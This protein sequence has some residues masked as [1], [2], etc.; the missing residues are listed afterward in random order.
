[1]KSLILIP[2]LLATGCTYNHT[3]GGGFEARTATELFAPSVTVI[4]RPASD[5]L[6]EYVQVIGGQ[7]VFGQLSGPASAAVGGW[8]IGEGLKQSGTRVNQSGGGAVQN[9]E[10]RTS[11]DQ[12]QDQGQNV[13]IK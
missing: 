6:P 10:Q 8:L 9:Q 12:N 13:N 11:Q 3:L 5:G 4:H 7:S 1:M 2:A